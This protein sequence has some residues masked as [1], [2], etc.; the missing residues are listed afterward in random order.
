VEQ[1]APLALRLVPARARLARPARNRVD[2]DDATPA[3]DL[4]PAQLVAER[5]RRLA[6]QERMAAAER[7]QVGAVG[8]CDLDAHEHLARCRNGVVD[9]LD[10]YVARP[11]PAQGPHGV[12]TTLSASPRR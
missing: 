10:P 4:D 7:L 6:E 11:V 1:G 9:L 3:L 2:R 8:E 5:R 12:K